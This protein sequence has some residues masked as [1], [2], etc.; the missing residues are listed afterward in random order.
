MTTSKV[1][2][3]FMCNG[4]WLHSLGGFEERRQNVHMCDWNRI[5]TSVLRM[6]PQLLG[7]LR[8]MVH[9]QRAST[10]AVHS[11]GH[12]VK[13]SAAG[14]ACVLFT[15]RNTV[16]LLFSS[17]YN[18]NCRRSRITS[19]DGGRIKYQAEDLPLDAIWVGSWF[20]SH[21]LEG[22]LAF[23]H[24]EER[25]QLWPSDDPSHN[26][27]LLFNRLPSTSTGGHIPVRKMDETSQL[28]QSY[29]E[30]RDLTS[31]QL[32]TAVRNRD[33]KEQQKHQ[34]MR[35]EVLQWKDSDMCTNDR[36]KGDSGRH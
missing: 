13:N 30:S 31:N 35:V 34:G 22:S 14:T 8:R 4:T 17:S 27:N 6:C 9:L 20:C 15:A 5:F 26:P 21:S 25:P 11:A 7:H 2:K 23:S 3:F 24:Q 16:L 36:I 32:R 28:F 18:L 33:G 1:M 12:V 10:P 19:C 29:R